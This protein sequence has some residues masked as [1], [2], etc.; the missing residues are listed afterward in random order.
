MPLTTCLIADRQLSYYGVCRSNLVSFCLLNNS[1]PQTVRWNADVYVL[2]AWLYLSVSSQYS[3]P[4]SRNVR[5]YTVN[6]RR[7]RRRPRLRLCCSLIYAGKMVTRRACAVVA[8]S[9]TPAGRR[10]RA[11]VYVSPI[12]ETMSRDRKQRS[13][14]EVRAELLLPIL[15]HYPTLAP[16]RG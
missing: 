3:A 1:S 9:G 12:N 7:N 6:H 10:G 13:Y 5:R 8:V 2:P 14:E 16:T 4:V 11:R 15:G